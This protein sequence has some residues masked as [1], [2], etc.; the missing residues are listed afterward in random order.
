MTSERGTAAGGKTKLT[1]DEIAGVL[2]F[3]PRGLGRAM[4]EAIYW[5]KMARCTPDLRNAVVELIML[6]IARQTRQLSDVQVD[7][8]LV[9]AA[10][11]WAKRGITAEQQH[12]LHRAEQRLERVK[13]QTWP[14]NT[15]ELLPKIVKAIISEISVGRRCDSC[16]GRGTVEKERYFSI[17]KEC[18]GTG[19]DRFCDRRRAISIGCDQKGYIRRWKTVYEW[20]FN[21]MSRVSRDA[22]ADVLRALAKSEVT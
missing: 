3:V 12:A 4:L 8:Q 17:C 7:V 9:K 20:I 1:P 19:K 2:A 13:A 5:P 11:Q 21:K 6:E 10:I 22:I 14:R 18:K 16:G 15:I